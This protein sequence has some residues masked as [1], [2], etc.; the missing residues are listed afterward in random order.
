MANW[1][2]TTTTK[3]T[4][5]QLLEV[6]THPEEIRRWSPVDFDVDDLDTGAA[7]A[8]HPRAGDRQA[9]RRPGRL[10]RRGPRRRHRRCSSSPR[11]VRSGIDVRYEL[12]PAK[13]G[14]ELCASVSLRR[15]GGITGRL[16]ANATAALLSAGVLEGAAGRIARAAELPLTFG[17]QRAQTAAQPAFQP[18]QGDP[19][20]YNDT[21]LVAPLAPRQRGRGGSRPRP[22]LRRRRLGRRG[23]TRRLARGPGRP[24]HRDHGPERLRQVHADAPARRPRPPHRGQRRDRGRGHHR[25]GRQAAHAAPP[26]AH[27]LRVP[28]VQPGPDAERGG[29]RDAAALDRRPQDRPLLRRLGDRAGR[30]STIAARTARPSCPAASSSAWRWLVRSWPSPRCCSPTSPPATSTPGRA[31]R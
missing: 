2:A 28:G 24:V 6:L 3:A 8:R 12:A 5:E 10:R 19:A 9:R 25:D 14:S 20:M 29:E 30:A 18:N 23:R 27:R 15:G 22:P 13:T 21:A 26:Q 17:K 7:G 31:P 11:T 4:P 16:V 1:T